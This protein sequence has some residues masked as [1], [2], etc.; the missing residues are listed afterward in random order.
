MGEF[1]SFSAWVI[2]LTVLAILS[3]VYEEKLIQVEDEIRDSF[4]QVFR[5]WKKTK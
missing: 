4:S 3:I 5:R 2:F 1:F